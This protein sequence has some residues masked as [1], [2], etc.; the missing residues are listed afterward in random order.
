MAHQTVEDENLFEQ[1]SQHSGEWRKRGFSHEEYPLLAEA[2]HWA[3]AP[4][5][6]GWQLRLPQL[7]A[8]ETY[9]FLR[10][11]EETP[12][13]F[14]LYEK[15][16]PPHEDKAAFL[17]AISVSEAAFQKANFDLDRLWKGLRSDDAF[18]R[19]FRLEAL[20]ETMA[21]DYPSYILALA[22]GAGKTALIGAI[23]A[24][25]FAMALEY[26][27]GPFVQKSILERRN[28]RPACCSRKSTT[29]AQWWTG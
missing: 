19:E 4:D 10:M 16:F 21:L 29:G 1:L 18:V 7:R 9:R 11:V 27:D 12:R 25:E 17:K 3:A 13:I 15:H 24:T 6:A 14:E 2:L 23:I 20:R 28:S 8:L 22:M 5:G 26:P